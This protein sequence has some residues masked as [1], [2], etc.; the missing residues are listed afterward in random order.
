[1][2]Q[3]GTVEQ[4]MFEVPWSGDRSGVIVPTVLLTRIDD[5]PW[6]FSMSLCEAFARAWGIRWLPPKATY[7]RWPEGSE[8]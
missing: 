8:L 4:R 1:M 2:S 7:T 3:H 5:G 6:E